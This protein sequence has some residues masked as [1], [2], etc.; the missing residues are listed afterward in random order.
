[1]RRKWLI[2]NVCLIVCTLVAGVVHSLDKPSSRRSKNWRRAGGVSAASLS[3][4]RGQNSKASAISFSPP[5]TEQSETST[6]FGSGAYTYWKI[7]NFID[8]ISVSSDGFVYGLFD[9]EP[10]RFNTLA[11]TMEYAIGGI[12][13]S[14]K[15]AYSI[16][17]PNSGAVIVVGE[18]WSFGDPGWIEVFDET[19]FTFVSSASIAVSTGYEDVTPTNVTS[20]ANGPIFVGGYS[21]HDGSILDQGT[22]TPWLRKFN[23]A[24]VEQEVNLMN[25]EGQIHDISIGAD[26]YLYVC[27]IKGSYDESDIWIGK[28]DSDLQL[29]DEKIINT[30]T[31]RA[32]KGYSLAIDSNGD[33]YVSGSVYEVNGGTNA[34]IGR[35]DQNLDL[36]DSVTSIG[37]LDGTDD[38]YDDIVIVRNRIYVTGVR[39]SEDKV[40]SQNPRKLGDMDMV[41]ASY[42]KGLDFVSE[43]IVQGEANLNDVGYALAADENGKLYVAGFTEDTTTTFESGGI[44]YEWGVAVGW[45]SQHNI[46]TSPVDGEKPLAYPNPFRPGKGHTA[47]SIDNL[48]ETGTLKL[49]T[50][51]GELVREIP[52]VAGS[53]SWDVKNTAGE[54]VTSGVYFGVVDGQDSDKTFKVVI[55]R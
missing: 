10:A 7:G 1:M 20:L 36:N 39:G 47:M 27:G 38:S 53:A 16:H 44:T 5:P 11:N 4:P 21:T 14:D 37:T 31:G 18:S 49:F 19:N 40:I 54:S 26:G 52:V 33:V 42:T 35:L 15:N 43:H 23:S 50:L 32:D 22:I 28:F 17:W 3:A 48:P 24:L 29:V 34:W 12:D 30:S 51:K 46:G 8:S 45:L 41:M 9:W 13:L 25:F 2:G 6:G 55:Q